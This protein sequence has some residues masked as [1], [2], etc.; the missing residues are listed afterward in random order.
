MYKTQ[1]LIDD[2]QWF[3][4]WTNRLIDE[5]VKENFDGEITV[6]LENNAEG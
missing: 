2:N 3:V 6:T 4:D 5:L 1:E